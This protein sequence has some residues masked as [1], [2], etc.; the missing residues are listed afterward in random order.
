[1]NDPICAMCNERRGFI[2]MDDGAMLC[3]RCGDKLMERVYRRAAF[4]AVGTAIACGVGIA[5]L[6]ISFS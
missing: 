4:I 2:K 5:L 3:V 1:M 6:V